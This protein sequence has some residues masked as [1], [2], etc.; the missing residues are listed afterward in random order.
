MSPSRYACD[1]HIYDPIN[2][3]HGAEDD[4]ETP[5]GYILFASYIVHI[6]IVYKGGVT[7]N[8]IYVNYVIFNY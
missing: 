3:M 6:I 2:A 5:A 4:G 7:N 1:E 8:D